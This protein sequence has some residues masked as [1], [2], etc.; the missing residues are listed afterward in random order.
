RALYAAQTAEP[1]F[2]YRQVAM[3]SFDLRSPRFADAQAAAFQRQLLERVSALPG[4]EA[5]AQ[6]ERT[7]LS[8]GRT[9]TMFRL[10]AQD[11][12]H[13]IDLNTVSP[14]YFALIRIPIVRGRT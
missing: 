4:V 1:G 7:P 12:W 13:E 14:E 9:Q 2:D 8:P 3:A 10:P 6:V 11:Q 5:I